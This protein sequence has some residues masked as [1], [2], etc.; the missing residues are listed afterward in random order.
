MSSFTRD[1]SSSACGS[2]SGGSWQSKRQMSS[3]WRCS[4]ADC[5]SEPFDDDTASETPPPCARC[6]APLR[7][8]VV[9]F[10]EMIGAREEVDAKRA[11]RDCDLFLAVGTSGTVW[12][13]SSFVRAAEYAGA[14]S[15]LVNA[16]DVPGAPYGRV[17]VGRAEEVL[18]HLEQVT[19]SRELQ[20]ALVASEPVMATV[21][22]QKRNGRKIAEQR[23]RYAWQSEE[24]QYV[25]A[26]LEQGEMEP[27][28]DDIDVG[29]ITPIDALNLLF[30]LQK[31]RN[32]R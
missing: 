2:T 14:R 32:K 4:S 22:P 15:I 29:A 7:P 16:E 6:G 12:P 10:D 31:K 5:A 20:T 26:M 18:Q 17:I 13:T 9:L 19:H 27:E 21:G 11:L 23:E 8:D 28:I 25:A 24:A 30:L 3:G 1:G